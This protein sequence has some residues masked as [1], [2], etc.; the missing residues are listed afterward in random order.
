[1]RVLTILLVSA[2]GIAVVSAAVAY[3]M[4]K[5]SQEK[6]YSRAVSAHRKAESYY[7][8]G[9]YEMAEKLYAKS[10]SMRDKAGV[11]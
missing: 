7:E 8:S 9:D 2:A 5:P 4:S 6:L 10:E 1:M 3:F 11:A